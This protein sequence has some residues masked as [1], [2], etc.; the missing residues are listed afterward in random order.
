MF[1]EKDKYQ[2]NSIKKKKNKEIDKIVHAS[3]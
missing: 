2:Y 3:F 1:W